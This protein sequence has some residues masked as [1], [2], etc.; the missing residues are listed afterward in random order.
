MPEMITVGKDGN[1]ERRAS[2]QMRLCNQENKES[3]LAALKSSLVDTGFTFTFYVPSLW[4]R[5]KAKR[6]KQVFYKLLP[7]VLSHAK[8][9]LEEAG[10]KLTVDEKYWK[11]ICKGAL[12]PEKNTVFAL[13]LTCRMSLT[14]ANE[15]LTV[16]G[17]T[18]STDKVCDV[19][20]GYLLE[21]QIFNEEMRDRC[22]VE[23]KITSLPIARENV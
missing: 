3:I 21:Q 13:A 20:V 18:L 12:I 19:V 4:A 9:T 6:S 14:D 17:Y 2:E 22:L 1:I 8:I 11:K 10:K 5:L 15:L 16:C 23:Y 7:V